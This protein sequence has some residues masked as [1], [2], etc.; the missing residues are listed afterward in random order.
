MGTA[1]SKVMVDTEATATMITRVDTMAT[2]ADMTTVST[3]CP[4]GFPPAPV[5]FL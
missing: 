1:A 4:W 5:R 3:D 2:A